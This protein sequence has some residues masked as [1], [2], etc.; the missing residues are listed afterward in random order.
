MGS[1]K[2]AI[3][4]GWCLFIIPVAGN[5]VVKALVNAPSTDNNS[6]FVNIDARPTDPLMI[7]DVPVTTGL[8][9]Q[10]VS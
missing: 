4:V 1:R 9:S 5:Y 7:W 10:T 6:F 3:S 8:P 2:A